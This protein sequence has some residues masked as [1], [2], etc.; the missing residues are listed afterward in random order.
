[1]VGVTQTFHTVEKRPKA[2]SA[3]ELSPAAAAAT[4]PLSAP[5]TLGAPGKSQLPAFAP[6]ALRA[7]P[8]PLRPIGAKVDLNPGAPAALAPPTELAVASIEGFAWELADDSAADG[9]EGGEGG[10]DE[11]FSLADASADGDLRQDLEPR[12]GKDL[13]SQM[14]QLQARAAT[15]RQPSARPISSSESGGLANEG[16]QLGAEGTQP[17]A[18]DEKSFD[19]L[20]QVAEPST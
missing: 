17:G 14:A 20:W 7:S 9:G 2:P 1:M 16:T 19:E 12:G 10:A 3:Q 5:A 4:Q 11:A 8:L 18:V 15:L 6:T 13:R